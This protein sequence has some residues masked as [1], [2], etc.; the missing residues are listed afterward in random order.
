MLRISKMT[1]ENNSTL[2]L[3]GTLA[4]PWV[5]ELGR[6]CNHAAVGES[7]LRL[8]CGGVSFADAKGVA[9]LQALRETGISLD[10]CSPFLEWQLGEAS[11]TSAER[12][13]R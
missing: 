13:G 5:E 9:L 3:E 12:G 11:T 1:E 6:L 8:D 7:G 2:R 4:G 10:N